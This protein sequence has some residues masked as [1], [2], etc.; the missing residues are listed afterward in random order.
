MMSNGLAVLEPRHDFQSM[1]KIAAVVAQSGLF[2]RM[3]EPQVLTLMMLCESE[4]IHPI[5]ALQLYDI[6]E[7][8][9]ALKAVA[10][11]ARFL[12]SGGQVDWHE[13]SN[14]AAEA[15]FTH[16]K[17]CPNGVRVRYTIEDA[18]LAC[19]THKDNWKK[20][21]ADMLV[22]RVCSRG[23]KRANPACILGM[24]LPESDDLPPAIE[25]QARASLVEKLG[26]RL[27]SPKES[28]PPVAETAAELKSAPEPEKPA[29][30]PETEL[31]KTIADAVLAMNQAL[32]ELANQNPSN[33]KLR[34][35][36]R[37]PQVMNGVINGYIA[38]GTVDENAV[39][40]EKGK[41]DGKKVADVL[42]SLWTE[43]AGDVEAAVAKYLGGKMTELMGPATTVTQGELA[44]A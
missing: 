18:K 7:G 24:D 26:K 19:L 43:D 35:A 31:G 4:G 1:T 2:G 20:N 32:S 41:R 17:T 10:L 11:L 22:A 28:H 30:E 29:K 12:E 39:K 5:K 44:V 38:A 8:K 16:P 40:N 36:F 42:Q 33:L 21:P 3:T 13:Q 23:A 6:I 15:T 37:V 27:E 25:V 9:P 14:T 34:E